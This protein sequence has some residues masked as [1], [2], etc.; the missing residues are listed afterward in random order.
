MKHQP[1]SWGSLFLQV[2][3]L[4]SLRWMKIM[5]QPVNFSS[6]HHAINSESWELTTCILIA[7]MSELHWNKDYYFEELLTSQLCVLNIAQHVGW[8]PTPTCGTDLPT[9]PSSACLLVLSEST[10][11]R[12]IC[13]WWGV[14][15]LCL[16]S[17]NAA[18]SGSKEREERG[19]WP[20]TKSA[21]SCDT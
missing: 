1:K 15:W 18:I 9:L 7:C 10:E 20:R 14:C 11:D 13:C 8:P 17:F 4:W 16:V 3:H 21:F 12:N 6:L 2:P 5:W 19:K